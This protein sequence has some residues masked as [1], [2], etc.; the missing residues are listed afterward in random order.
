MGA[1]GFR[2]PALALLCA[3]CTSIHADQRTFEG[4]TWRVTAINSVQTPPYRVWPY[5]VWF[6]G[7]YM[8]GVICNNFQA[9][10]TVAGGFIQLGGMENTE[11]G[12]DGPTMQLEESAF[13]IFH[14]R[15]MRISWASSR[16]VTLSNGAGSLDLELQP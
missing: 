13:A 6:S 3:A 9:P 4:T 10:Y 7:G 16:N 11:R 8:R 15:P 2:A 14:R 5:R 1:V 12:C